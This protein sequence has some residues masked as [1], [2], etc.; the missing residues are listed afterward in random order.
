MVKIFPLWALMLL[1]AP[2]ERLFAQVGDAIPRVSYFSA[3]EEFYS[4]NYQRAERDFRR[5]LRRGVRTTQARWIDS[6]CYHAMLGEV[7]FHQGRNAE[8]LAEFDQACRLQLA[9]P[10]WLTRV[11]FVQQPRPDPNRARR[12]APWGRTT[13][14]AV[15]GHFPSTRQVLLGQSAEE[16]QRVA[17]EGGVLASPQYWRV[18]VAEVVRCSTLAIRRRSELL[19]PLAAHDRMT[20][21]LTDTLARGGLAIPNHW[22]NVWVE[23]QLGLAQ[24]SRG[25]LADA[26][27]HL[28]RALLVDG[29]LDHP[30][31]CVALLE[32]GRLAMAGE[33][34]RKAARLLGEASFSAFLYENW[35]V[36]VESLLA[37]QQNHFLGAGN[38]NLYPPLESAA[39]WARQRGMWHLGVKLWLAQA[40]SLA[41]LGQLEQATAVLETASRRLGRMRGGLPEVVQLRVQALI[42]LQAGRV[43]PDPDMLRPAIAAQATVSL[44]NFQISRI[45]HL[46]DARDISPRIAVALYQKLL[47]DPQGAAWAAHPFDSLALLKTAHDGAFDRWFLAALERKDVTLAVEISERAKRRRF[48]A[49]LPLGGRLL[50]LR[51]LLEMPEGELA[52]AAALERQQLLGHFPDYQLLSTE[53][54]Q[55]RAQLR[56][57]P[58]VAEDAKE[59]RSLQSLYKTW[60]ENAEAR[61]QLLLRMAVGPLPSSMT[62]PPLRKTK[63]LQQALAP[64]E[65]LALF[66]EVNGDLYGFLLSNNDYHAWHF[67][68]GRH[69]HST[70]ANFLRELGNYG[71]NHSMTA[72]ALRSDSW[73]KPASELFEA[74]FGDSR[75]DPTKTSRLTIVPDGVLWYV[76]FEALVLES[77]ESRVEGREQEG[78]LIDR[79]LIHY[80]PTAAL[81]VGEGRPFRRVQQ[82]AIIANNLAAELT[83][84]FPKTLH[85]ISLPTP[86]PEQGSLIAPLLDQLVV[87]DN[88]DVKKSKKSKQATSYDWS[89]LANSR[90]RSADSLRQWFALPFG[91]PERIVLTGFPTVVENGLKG[92]RRSEGRLGTSDLPAGQE[93]FQAVCGLMATGARTIL[94]SRWR[95]QGQTNLDLVREYVQELPHVSAR[96]AWQR[97]VLLARESPLDAQLEP[98]IKLKK[99]KGPDDGPLLAEHPFF[100]AGYLLIDQSGLVD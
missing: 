94:L 81:A 61:E 54:K 28:N 76:P 1:L 91:G 43:I 8:A 19:G 56:A 57:G 97:S 98:R 6:I 36:L 69:L 30:L 11:K 55:L 62:F 49:S 37:G 14:Q 3:V 71:A 68:D 59:K 13:R 77:P 32:Q 85:P 5:E 46:Y 7:L 16:N 95:T 27:L 50:S 38:E 96:E 89:P 10:N 67:E 39:A 82:T 90:G 17:R 23:L 52:N 45:G 73:R 75:L 88:L 72:E 86:L 20:R 53:A 47:E 4:G 80:G 87:L 40:E 58:I 42:N 18:N 26:Q 63:E 33:D 51:R 84:R 12:I 99:S 60:S 15:P 79:T 65:A 92:S 44:R 74:I 48:Y 9:Y 83:P 2:G 41:R 66:H 78:G 21:Q 70:L 93:I 100:W 22:S 35:D 64:E 31:T 24:A 25:N 29:R 34:H